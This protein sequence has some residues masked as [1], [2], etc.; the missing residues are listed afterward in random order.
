[1]HVCVCVCVYVYVCVQCGHLCL[2]ADHLV[3]LVLEGQAGN[4]GRLGELVQHSADGR[5][6]VRHAEVRVA[7]FARHWR[8]RGGGLGV[9]E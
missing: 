9:S 5:F 8:R 4:G 1:M 6:R 7:F 2:V 3:D